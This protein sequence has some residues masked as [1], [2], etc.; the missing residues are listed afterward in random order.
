[1]T[2]TRWE[3]KLATGKRA[4]WSGKN[5]TDAAIR[6]VDCHQTETVVA[7]READ[8]HG[9]HILGTGTITEG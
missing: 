5:G 6:F 4:T 3:L 8:R 9:L 2:E 1:M 7:Y